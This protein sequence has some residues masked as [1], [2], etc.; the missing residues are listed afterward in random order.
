MEWNRNV[1]QGVCAALT[2]SLTPVN[3]ADVP[4]A[5]GVGVSLCVP[6]GAKSSGHD[7]PTGADMYGTGGSLEV[8]WQSPFTES[9]WD[10]RLRL[11][12]MFLDKGTQPEPPRGRPHAKTSG[13]SLTYDFICTP[14]GDR[15]SGFYFV[16]AAGL[17]YNE[18]SYDAY[19]AQSSSGKLTGSWLPASTDCATFIA[20]APGIG[21]H[22]SKN[23]E[24]ELRYNAFQKS[25]SLNIL[26][27]FFGDLDH[28][29][30]KPDFSPNHWSATIRCRF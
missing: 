16:L 22:I 4:P 3:A 26:E 28:P 18:A 6:A 12:G 8:S 23:M 24:L 13:V 17:L 25:P 10:G 21:M 19:E 27:L 20:A 9:K 7:R 5:W 15:S 1:M 30:V 11:T 14:F 2:L 29:G